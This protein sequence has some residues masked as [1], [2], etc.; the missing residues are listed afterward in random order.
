MTPYKL[1]M[2]AAKVS[3]ILAINLAKGIRVGWVNTNFGK[4]YVHVN[5]SGRSRPIHGSN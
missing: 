5:L 2:S 3:L 4:T 1:P